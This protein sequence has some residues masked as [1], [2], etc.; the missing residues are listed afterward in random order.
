MHLSQSE[1]GTVL[2]TCRKKRA[3]FRLF[4]RQG[5]QLQISQSVGGL[6][7]GHPI[8]GTAKIR[9]NYEIKGSNSRLLLNY[10]GL[11]SYQQ[12]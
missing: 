9:S 7:S 12:V 10:G 1:G 5:L 11:P 6:M 2:T 8:R 3:D 4:N